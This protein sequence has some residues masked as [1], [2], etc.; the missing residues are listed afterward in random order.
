MSWTVDELD[1]DG[2]DGPLL[3]S[4]QGGHSPTA[5]SPVCIAAALPP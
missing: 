5:T 2:A 3:P 4:T 1:G